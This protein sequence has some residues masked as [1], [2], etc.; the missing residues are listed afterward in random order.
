MKE[1]RN[2]KSFELGPVPR[3]YEEELLKGDNL[4]QKGSE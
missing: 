1:G 3:D 4:I 2:L